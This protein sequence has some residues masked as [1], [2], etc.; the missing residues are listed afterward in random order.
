GA[1]RWRWRREER[2]VDFPVHVW[3]RGWWTGMST[4]RCPPGRV[5]RGLAFCRPRRAEGPSHRSGMARPY[6]AST[7]GV[8][9]N[10][11]RWP[12]LVLGA[13]LALKAA[14][15]EM[16]RGLGICRIPVRRGCLVGMGSSC[17]PTGRHDGGGWRPGASRGSAPGCPLGPR[18][19][20]AVRVNLCEI[21]CGIS[22]QGAPESAL[23]PDSEG[24]SGRAPKYGGQ[25][26]IRT[27]GAVLAH[28]RFPSVRI[29][30]LCHLSVIGLPW[31]VTGVGY[32]G[33]GGV[34]G[35]ERGGV[36]FR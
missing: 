10:L 18:W 3:I 19:G 21:P 34:Q 23:P 2:S 22:G 20:R 36:T 25:R 14:G 9:V 24:V 12:R 28:T 17:A 7:I 6:R 15:R 4:L 8:S 1:R 35:K 5:P 29:R 13:P 11:G 16:R 33:T 32:P 30:P 26:G 31:E 27:L